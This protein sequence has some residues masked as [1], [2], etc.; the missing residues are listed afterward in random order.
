MPTGRPD[1]FGLPEWK[2]LHREASLVRQ[3][4]GTGATALGRANYADNFG[5]YYSAFFSLSIGIERFAKLILI[6]DYAIGQN[7]ALPNQSVVRRFGHNLTQLLQ[8]A[9]NVSLAR[10]FALTYSKP[11][12]YIC[13]A[14]MNVLDAFADASRGR[15]A[16]FEAIGNPQFQASEEPVNKWW[17]EVV[18]PILTLHY[19]GLDREAQV[20]HRAHVISS[21][22]NGFAFVR[23]FDENG[24]EMQD[25]DVAS[26]RTGQTKWAQKYGRYYTLLVVR[27]LASIFDKLIHEAVYQHNIVAFF[28]HNEFFNTFTV[29]D[30]F[31]RERKVWPLF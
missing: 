21:M 3:I 19:R 13:W 16:N 10:N 18:E 1:P 4:L 6:A 25:V 20:R 31:L 29:G 9:E 11:T 2:A 26:Q 15:Y 28:G 8:N 30:E 23:Y 24:N 12:E 27:W 14:A 17:T 7:G 5:E 22:L